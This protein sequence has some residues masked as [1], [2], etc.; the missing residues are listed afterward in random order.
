ME[1]TRELSRWWGPPCSRVLAILAVLLPSHSAFADTCAQL[2]CAQYSLPCCAGMGAAGESGV[3]KVAGNECTDG[4]IVILG[5]AST[6]LCPTANT[7]VCGGVCCNTSD[8]NCDRTACCQNSSG[9]GSGCRTQNLDWQWCCHDNKKC[10]RNI[11]NY[12]EF[13]A[14]TANN[15]TCLTSCPPDQP[16]CA[17]DCCATN[18]YCGADGGCQPKIRFPPDVCDG[19]V[20]TRESDAEKGA[21]GFTASDPI[22]ITGDSAFSFDRV[23]DLSLSTPNGRFAFHRTY[24]SSDEPWRAITASVAAPSGNFRLSGVPKP[25]GSSRVDRNSLR[26]THSLY[27]FVDVR[28]SAYVTNWVVRPPVGTQEEFKKCAPDAGTTNCW[29]ERE[30]GSPGQRNRL[31]RQSDG[32]F[33]YHQA[34]GKRYVYTH[35]T[36]DAGMYFLSELGTDDG[37]LIAVVNYATPT[38]CTS[39]TS[40]TVPWVSS[41][42]L[43]GGQQLA[44]S[45][46]L[47]A[48]LDAGNEC[49]LSSVSTGSG[50]TALVSYAY[51]Q[52][53]AG[54]LSQV[55]T[56]TFTE[57]FAYDAGFKVFRQNVAIV[58]HGGAEVTSA[59]DRLGSWS[60]SG[61]AAGDVYSN[62]TACSTLPAVERS[63]SNS[64]P[65]VGDGSDTTAGLIEEYTYMSGRSLTRETT[66]P[67]KRHDSCTAGGWACSEG[68]VHWVYAGVAGVGTTCSAT[69]PGYLYATKNKRGNWTVTPTRPPDGGVDSNFEVAARWVG[70]PSD[71]G[72][73]GALPNPF[74][75]PGANG[76]NALETTTFT[77]AYQNRSQSVATET[78]PSALS[79]DAGVALTTWVRDSSNRVIRQ[80]QSGATQ[81]LSGSIEHVVVARFRSYD[82]EGRVE[83]TSG[84]CFVAH[85]G[86]T[87][88]SDDYP[89]TTYAYF[90]NGEFNVGKLQSVTRKVSSSLDLVTSYANYTA[91]GEPT[92]VT[93]ENGVVTTFTYVGHNVASRSVALSD[94]GT[95]AWSYTWENEKLAG[96]TFP[97]GNKDTFCYRTVASAS[98]A[99]SEGTWTGRL[100]RVRK[101]ASDA[102]WAEAIVYDYWADG[103]LKTET[104]YTNDGGTPEARFKRTHAADAHKRQTL[105][106]TG[107]SGSFSEARGY[108]SADNL[109]A[110]G[111]DFNGAPS[112]CREGGGALSKLCAQMGYDR[113]E[114]LRQ[115][116]LY[117]D[118]SSSSPIRA[119]IDYDQRGN[120]SRVTTGCDGE[121][122]CSVERGGSDCSSGAEISHDYVTDDFGNVVAVQLSGTD[123]SSGGRG[124]VLFEFDARGNLSKKQNNSQRSE[125]RYTAHEYDLLGRRTKTLEY[126][127]GS[128]GLE[129]TWAYDNDTSAIADPPVSCGG[130][131]TATLGRL[132]AV[133]DPFMTRWF[134]YDAL[135]RVT[136]EVRR[137]NTPTEE[138]CQGWHLAQGYSPN[139]N[140]TSIRYGLGRTV[141]YGYG[142]GALTDRIDNVSFSYFHTD[143]GVEQRQLVS[144]V[145]WEPYGGLRKYRAEPEEFWVDYE[146]GAA[147][148]APAA[149]C[150]SGQL[151]EAL[152]QT[153]RLRSLRVSSAS[154]EV[155]RR[156]YTW[157]AD[158]VERIDTCYLGGGDGGSEY[159]SEV[160]A[161]DAGAGLGYDGLGRLKGGVSPTFSTMG[162]PWAERKFE[163]DA[164]SNITRLVSDGTDYDY[165]LNTELAHRRDWVSSFG[166]DSWNKVD[167]THD[168]DGRVLAMA[169][170]AMISSAS[171]SAWAL[172]YVGTNAI[173][174]G[175][176]T[177][178]RG[179]AFTTGS[180]TLGYNYYYDHLSRR[181]FAQGPVSESYF[182]YDLGHQ[183]LE[184]FSAEPPLDPFEWPLPDPWRVAE[185]FIWLDGR[186]IAG[187]R[188]RIQGEE[189]EDPQIV[190]VGDELG[191][192]SRGGDGVACGIYF[193]VTDHIGKPVLTLDLE[194]RVSGVGEYDPRG[195]VNRVAMNAQ[196][197]HPYGYEDAGQPFTA[198]QRTLGGMPVR[199]RFHFPIID[200][201]I[202]CYGT[203]SPND[204]LFTFSEPYQPVEHLGSY[205][206]GETWSA[207]LNGHVDANQATAGV[208]WWPNDDLNCS[209]LDCEA[210]CEDPSMQ[211]TGFVLREYEY[212]RTE[213]GVSPYFPNFRYPG[214]Y[215]D[216]ETDLHENWHRYFSPLLGEYLSPE[217]LLRSPN[218]IRSEASNGRATPTYA[219]AAN[220]PIKHTDPTG[221]FTIDTESLKQCGAGSRWNYVYDVGMEVAKMPRCSAWFQKTFGYDIV[222]AFSMQGGTRLVFSPKGSLG[223]PAA[224][225]KGTAF[226]DCDVYRRKPVLEVVRWLI[227]E[228]GHDA[229]RNSRNLCSAPV[230]KNDEEDLIQE[231]ERECSGD[232]GT[233]SP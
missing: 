151:G 33:E 71:G 134:Q 17:E 228:L 119:C 87:S 138:V 50:P 42:E 62:G 90:T 22:V 81:L 3:C 67:I 232:R 121:D 180:I 116:D 108:D 103:T 4:T 193:I 222:H 46:A 150:P 29:A 9:P 78:R 162:G 31:F 36:T 231:G 45:Y 105:V 137:L 11:Q 106:T 215:W 41:V 185:E 126:Y 201:E 191:D 21:P 57:G 19:P 88:C 167:I 27:S 34:D 54:L 107:A 141:T 49:V 59:S 227:H 38:P 209:P 30:S 75:N 156:T 203:P 74:P 114:R 175:S 104:R 220:N 163:Y 140:L 181:V 216:P 13:T 93:D 133:R 207:W 161:A 200:T 60:F 154:R 172:E 195:T 20:P 91:L 102:G 144:N 189:A 130:G 58:T 171:T 139:G 52:D 124:M 56:L 51:E 5:F 143:G 7:I 86:I 24:Y 170:P 188:S 118:S 153:Q 132:R 37:R 159:L 101:E 146:Q 94:G 165:T 174:A 76:V 199:F 55:Q 214:Q 212:Q 61:A 113:A 6:Q 173:T 115:L 28:P 25:F 210:S 18:E 70:V 208:F 186:P 26:W 176:E 127:G 97:E 32:G 89:L 182:L 128:P 233:Y 117:T 190:H 204:H 109:A 206:R 211:Y 221:L 198:T 99:C 122:T 69:N 196:S 85:E 72:S 142:S 152:D 135:G 194:G 223:D 148:S 82:S 65:R 205:S 158:Q 23:E 147:T 226:I 225:E 157:R 73:N 187:I 184:T 155:Y 63:V 183:L 166:A 66:V 40:A 179:V 84:P 229:F 12:S 35:A 213:S 48:T 47:K 80:Y 217:P 224:Y 14:A 92:S 95:V 53:L 79:T 39:V 129:L 77:Y 2:N 112:Y 192:C 168:Y 64:A 218:F 230:S 136:K 83:T 197:E 98:A 131:P 160:Y 145:A 164:R 111:P 44:F 219:Y 120:V 8:S 123:D 96:V 149:R 15:Q 100:Q 110:L 10:N 177:V 202:D 169:S 178:M 43:G 125:D 1:R 16:E 68:S